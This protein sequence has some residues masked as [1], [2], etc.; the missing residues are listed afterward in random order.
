MKQRFP[1]LAAVCFAALAM[2]L[3]FSSCREDSIINSSLTPAV[4]NIHTFGIGPDFNNGTDTVTILTKTVFQDSVVTSSRNNGFPIYHALGFMEDPFAGRTFAGI[5]SQFTP[6]ATGTTISTTPDSVV[7]VLPFSGFVWGDT[8]TQQAHTIKVYA[9]SEGF[10]KDSSFYNYNR[11]ATAAQVIGTGTVV[12]GHSNGNSGSGFIQDSVKLSNGQSYT[13]HLRIKLDANWVAN[14]FIPAVA[15]DSSYAAF[16]TQ[17]PG[18]FIAETDTTMGMG[19]A[20]KSLPYF[21]LNG[22]SDIYG[23]AAILV[24]ANGSDTAT[25]FPYNETYCAHF[26]RITRNYTGYPIASLL[27]SSNSSETVAMQNG[28]GAAID[29]VLPDIK[30]LAQKLP[31]GAII[32]KAE[33]AFVQVNTGYQ[34]QTFF[35]PLRLYPQG[36]NAS[37][38]IY[39]IADRYPVNDASLN[40]MDGMASSGTRG[41]NP[42]TLYRIN[43]PRELQQAIVAGVGSLHLR[44][45]GTVN[46]PAAYRVVLGGRA[47][48]NANYRPTLNIIY[49]KQ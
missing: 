26:N 10:S 5:Y 11:K 3:S 12:T 39:T 34:D 48:A 27:S 18:L 1:S 33:I 35:P 24:Y 4:D 40:F 49:S 32:N 2:A 15:Y 6:T 9:I 20:P 47:N 41:G 13:P 36:V 23:S 30:G 31:A 17:F 46:F 29:F 7:L 22:T 44:I 45:G 43:F 28:P 16:T 21:R 8:T 25:Q 19:A 38:G 37:N 42:V 14:S